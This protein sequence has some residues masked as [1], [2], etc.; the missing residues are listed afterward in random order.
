MIKSRKVII[1]LKNPEGRVFNFKLKGLDEI[2][3]SLENQIASAQGISANFLHM[4]F[5]KPVD[6]NLKGTTYLGM[7]HNM[8][9]LVITDEEIKKPL[10]NPKPEGNFFKKLKK[11][12]NKNTKI[13]IIE[14]PRI[15]Q[16]PFFITQLI[17]ISE[18]V[19][20]NEVPLLK[21][22]S[23]D[24]DL[25]YPWQRLIISG[26]LNDGNELD[27]SFIGAISNISLNESAD[28][29]AVINYNLTFRGVLE[30]SYV[31]NK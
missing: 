2:R 4:W 26:Y 13:N 15:Q 18:T 22:I 16:F 29:L 5:I 17:K 21:P 8:K 20:N 6:I 11:E 28:K 31:Y 19:R 10:N 23:F 14:Y 30:T 24:K 7:F 3:F 27:I 1:K 9:D 12:E 25:T